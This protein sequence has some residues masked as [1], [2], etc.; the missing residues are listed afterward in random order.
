MIH[1]AMVC[2]LSWVGVKFSSFLRKPSWLK[3]DAVVAFPLML[4]SLAELLVAALLL[5]ALEVIA[6]NLGFMTNF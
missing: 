6:Y 2:I 5:E 3:M 1:K 4:L